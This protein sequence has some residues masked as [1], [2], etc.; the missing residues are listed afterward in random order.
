MKISSKDHIELVLK[1]LKDKGLGDE[2]MPMVTLP[3]LDWLNSYDWS[4]HEYIEFGS[5]NSTNY[6]AERF[7]TVDTIENNKAYFNKIKDTKASNV[8]AFN[9][10][11]MD[12]ELGQYSLVINYNTV[13][14]I[15]SDT[16]RFLTT[17]F[18]FKKGKPNLIFLDNSEWYPNTCKAIYNQGYVEIP[19]WGLRT[20]P[21]KDIEKC[22]S[23]FIK[24]GYNLPTKKYDYFSKGSS[25]Y[26]NNE[27]D[28]MKSILF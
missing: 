15:D 13:V 20:E 21:D 8:E 10:P 9:F 11:T 23:V 28:G 4:N 19:F 26:L 7:S 17:T 12:I 5:G 25:K 2:N 27:S 14:M 22:T 18:L 16:N 3:F 24:N 6:M 1:N